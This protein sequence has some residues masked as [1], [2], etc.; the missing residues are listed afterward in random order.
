MDSTLN[1]SVSCDYRPV[2]RAGAI[3]PEL[4][5]LGNLEQLGLESN[6]LSGELQ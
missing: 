5:Q 3:P 4:G 6:K 2:W 1:F